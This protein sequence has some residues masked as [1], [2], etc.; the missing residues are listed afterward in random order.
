MSEKPL[1]GILV[2][3]IVWLATSAVA[4]VLRRRRLGKALIEDIKHRISNL[5]EMKSYL[6]E[7]FKNNIKKGI[8]IENYARYTKDEF[9]FYE[10]VREDLYKYFGA[11]KLITF[12]RCYEALEEIEILMSGLN[13]DFC[14]YAKDKKQLSEEDVTLFGRRKDRIISVIEVLK[15]KEVRSIADL[16]TDYRGMVSAVQVI[17]K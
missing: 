3:I 2:G 6:E 17:K 14:E 16:P 12:I 13:Q 11:T 10:D 7:Y 9:P 4:F 8:T 5:E 15:R 1:I